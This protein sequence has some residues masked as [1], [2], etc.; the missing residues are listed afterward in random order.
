MLRIIAGKHKGRKIELDKQAAAH[1]RPT[2]GFARQ[3][4]FNILS[5]GSYREDGASSF[6]DKTVADICCGSG[7]F[8]LEALSRGAAQVTFVDMDHHALL[9]ARGNVERFGEL[10]HASFVRTN[11]RDLPPTTTAYA[12]IFID[13]PYFSGLLPTTLTRLH[14]GGWVDADSIIVIEHDVQETVAIP[15]P[16]RQVDER[17]YGRAMVRL[18]RTLP[19]AA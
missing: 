12:L 17:R 14:N 18:L 15:T 5:H 9:T 1:V 7:A 6:E 3:A 4:I 8:G 19:D 2:S 13:P 11:V 16:Y 10:E